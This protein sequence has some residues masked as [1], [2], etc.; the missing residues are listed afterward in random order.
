MGDMRA[1]SE[2]NG[3][4]ENALINGRLVERAYHGMRHLCNI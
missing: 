3:S 4:L 1:R 2:V